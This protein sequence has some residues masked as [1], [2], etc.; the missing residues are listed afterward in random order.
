VRTSKVSCAL[1][2]KTLQPRCELVNRT[3]NP[4]YSSTSHLPLDHVDGGVNVSSFI[5]VTKPDV[6]YFFSISKGKI[7]YSHLL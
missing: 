2:K 5:S 7:R 6:R 4:L 3:G 1:Q